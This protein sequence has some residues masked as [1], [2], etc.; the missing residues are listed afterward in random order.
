MAGS[1]LAGGGTNFV[2][3]LICL[4]LVDFFFINDITQRDT[5][6]LSTL[7]VTVRPLVIL[8]SCLFSLVQ[9]LFS[10]HSICFICCWG[11]SGEGVPLSVLLVFVGWS[12]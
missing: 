10:C 7:D 2:R 12:P 1:G 9:I 5:I 4:C 6:R 8:A 11:V 3:Q